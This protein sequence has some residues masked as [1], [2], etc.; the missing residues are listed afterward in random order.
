M[1]VLC[2]SSQSKTST[3][4]HIMSKVLWRKTNGKCGEGWG[5]AG[6]GKNVTVEELARDPE[7]SIPV[8]RDS[9]IL[10]GG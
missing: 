4:A 3:H 10:L 8:G 6:R 1:G 7:K 9:R 2:D 5:Q